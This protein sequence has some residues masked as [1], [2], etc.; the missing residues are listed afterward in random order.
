MD[1][2][3]TGIPYVKIMNKSYFKIL[4]YATHELLECCICREC[5]CERTVK[6]E[7]SGEGD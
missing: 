6:E 2:D 3:T 7:F 1:Q 5:M 4:M